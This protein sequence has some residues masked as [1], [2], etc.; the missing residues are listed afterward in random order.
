MLRTRALTAETFRS[1]I[2]ERLT[3]LLRSAMRRR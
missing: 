3:V 1:F 2:C